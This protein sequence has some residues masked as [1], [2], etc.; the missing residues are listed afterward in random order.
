MPLGF[1]YE[2]FVNKYKDACPMPPSEPPPP[3]S[4]P[5][6]G[7]TPIVGEEWINV[8]IPPAPVSELPPPPPPP[9]EVDVKANGEAPVIFKYNG[10][11]IMF[12]PLSNSGV[13]YSVDNVA[14]P[15]FYEAFFGKDKEGVYLRVCT[16]L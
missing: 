8:D 10:S 15:I 13:Q 12:Y 6:L 14:R 5:M 11:E 3:P 4:P 1:T 2:E 16:T 7:F 9:I